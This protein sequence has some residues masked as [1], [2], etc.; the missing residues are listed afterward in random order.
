[1]ISNKMIKYLSPN[2]VEALRYL[3]NLC[4]NER[5]IPID[6]K[7]VQIYPI[8]KP[9]DWEYDISKTKPIT[10]L[11][12]VRK[13]TIKIITNRLSMTL[14][15]HKILKG[16]NFAGLS[17]SSCDFPIIILNNIFEESCDYGKEL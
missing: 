2:I 10:L 15:A 14:A 16:N 17:G 12:I 3:A 1:M 7:M 4:L 9:Y 5:N 11:D 13:L 8:P 6:W